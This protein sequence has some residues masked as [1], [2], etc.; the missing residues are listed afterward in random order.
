MSNDSFKSNPGGANITFAA[1][2][3]AFISAAQLQYPGRTI[4]IVAASKRYDFTPQAD[5][6][7]LEAVWVAHF[8][9]W[10]SYAPEHPQ[11]R[12]ISRHFTE[13]K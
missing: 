6:T 5:I 8:L 4:D 12:L 2:D 1:S 7:P 11:W 3:V 9:A 10:R 13:V